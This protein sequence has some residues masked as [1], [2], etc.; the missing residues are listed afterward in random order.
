MNG[1]DI[2]VYQ[3]GINFKALDKNILY[4][5]IKATE[6]VGFIDKALKTNLNNIRQTNIKYGFYHFFSETSD[7]SEQAKAFYNAIR[8]TGYSL[9]PV[10]DI[11]SNTLKRS[12]SEVT[13]RAIQ[14]LKK[15]KELSNIDCIVYTYTSF[16]NSYL[17]KRLSSYKCWI[18]DY[19]KSQTVKPNYVWNSFVG[20]QYSG[21]GRIAGYRGMIDLNNFTKSIEMESIMPN[22]NLVVQA[23]SGNYSPYSVAV[24]QEELNKQ[25]NSKLVID[26]IAGPKTLNACIMVRIGARGNI[27]RWIQ[28]KL[29]SL[30]YNS[31]VVDGVFGVKTREAVMEFQRD[32]NLLVDGIVGNNTWRSLLGL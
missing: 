24:L 10:L 19:N 11:E 29:N 6:G 17:D 7:P 25:F 14:F 16:A 30:G 22:D 12:R 9:I 20:H 28:S 27:T 8:G 18:A 2:S 21:S 3:S 4:C 23:P 32:K 26:N 15:F 1:I 13:D 31:G 5:Y